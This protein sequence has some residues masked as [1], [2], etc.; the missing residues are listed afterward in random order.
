MVIQSAL[1][2]DTQGLLN[3][4]FKSL[5]SS[6]FRTVVPSNKAAH[7]IS[8]PPGLMGCKPGRVL[9][10][11]GSLEYSQVLKHSGLGV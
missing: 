4:S 2:T 1:S 5:S 7:D 11:P 6:F 10:L 9:L 8:G 3:N